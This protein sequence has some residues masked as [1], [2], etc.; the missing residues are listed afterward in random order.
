MEI[1]REQY[2]NE[3]IE[4]KNN[5]LIKV[6]T[7]L[8]RSGKSYLLNKLYRSYLLNHGIKASQIISFAFDNL[9]NI[10]ILDKYL[11]DEQTL[12]YDTR[13][14]YVVNPKK[15]ILY[16]N[17]LTKENDVYYFLLDEI[18]L[19][20][21]FVFA[22]NVL[23]S[24]DNYDIYV[25]GSNSKM[26]SKDVITEFRGRGDQ[27]HIYPLSFKEYYDSVNLSF[28]DAYLEYRYYGG[29]P[30]LLSIDDEKRKQEYLKDL[31]SEIY[32]KDITERNGIKNIDSFETLLNIL[33]SS[34]GSYTNPGK[35]EKTF[36][37]V[38]KVVYDHDTIKKHI[39][40]IKDA[41]LI[42]EAKR[43][44]IKRK[45]YIGSNSKYYFT[46][47][48][49]RNALI[50]FRQDEPTHI[51]ENII[52]ND[53][54]QKG[55]SVDVGI[56]EINSKT[57]KG[58]YVRKQLE[59]DF[60]CNRMTEKIYIQSAYSMETIEKQKQEMN[61]LLHIKDNFRKIIITKD[62]IKRYFT[63]E[64]IEVISLKEWLLQ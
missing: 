35:L 36:K 25:T 24:H 38:E 46:D 22:L 5:G 64:G 29:M 13:K 9:E 49:L 52:Y 18:Q 60:V 8:R 3:L 19:L 11:P 56:V 48:G 40:C 41:Y 16:I 39:D 15:F 10:M 53:L 61:S 55:Y 47:V 50:N 4:R 12:I 26:L 31:F 37:S 62:S 44:D 1:K 57:E 7:G 27:I 45:K 51:M 21:D 32:I 63:E 34:I 2:L 17:D 43:Y 28:E 20:G 14:N 54:L 58:N 6:I 33:S 30:Y 23:L 59:T 42:S